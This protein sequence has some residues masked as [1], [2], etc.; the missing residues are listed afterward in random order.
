[1]LAMRLPARHGRMRPV[2]YRAPRFSLDGQ[3]DPAMFG[4]RPFLGPASLL[5]PP[6]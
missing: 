2:R 4:V 1:M 6:H 5:R 3:F